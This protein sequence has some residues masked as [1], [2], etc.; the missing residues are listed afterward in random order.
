M[1]TYLPVLLPVL[2]IVEIGLA[3]HVVM[4]V[5]EYI[6]SE[7]KSMSREWSP[8]TNG[9]NNVGRHRSSWRKRRAMRKLQENKDSDRLIKFFHTENKSRIR[10]HRSTWKIRREQKAKARIRQKKE[11][12]AQE[13]RFYLELSPTN[14]EPGVPYVH[15]YIASHPNLAYHLIKESLSV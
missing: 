4:L 6:Y 14:V 13:Q 5:L 12:M 15:P 3:G 11:K 10:S 7:I 8:N 2:K 1:S 9:R